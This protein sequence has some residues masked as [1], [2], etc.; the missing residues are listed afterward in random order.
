MRKYYNSFEEYSEKNPNR[1]RRFDGIVRYSLKT[2]RYIEIMNIKLRDSK[3]IK[4]FLKTL[5]EAHERT[6]NSKLV[7]KLQ[8]N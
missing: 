7:F 4:K 2:Q 1:N 8:E 6:K 5:E 3:D